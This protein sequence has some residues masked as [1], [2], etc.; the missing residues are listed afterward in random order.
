MDTSLISSVIQQQQQ[1]VAMQVSMSL[2]Q[3]TQSVQKQVGELIVGLIANAAQP[4]GK[5]AGL[6]SNFDAVA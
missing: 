2:L 5:T 4:L 3:K 6:G 1:Q